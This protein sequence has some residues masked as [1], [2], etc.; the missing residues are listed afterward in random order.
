[1]FI[2]KVVN[3]MQELARRLRD[4]SLKVT[5]QRLA[6][7]KMLCETKSHPSAESIYKNLEPDHPTMSLATVYKTL[8]ALK[9]NGLVQELN[10]GENSF[11]YDAMTDTH[12]HIICTHCGC[13]EDFESPALD[14]IRTMVENETDYIIE[15]HQIYLY[16]RCKACQAQDNKI[17]V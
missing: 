13:V 15:S 5:P 17:V 3:V 8:D 9:R 7:F 1:M 10:V 12:P 11:R 2:H 16:G 6:I 4:K 14:N